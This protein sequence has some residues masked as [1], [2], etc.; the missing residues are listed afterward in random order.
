MKIYRNGKAIELTETEINHLYLEIQRRNYAEE[1]MLKLI[2]DYD[3]DP[4]KE[5]INVMRIVEDV[6]YEIQDNDTIWDCEQEACRKAIERYL[7]ERGIKNEQYCKDLINKWYSDCLKYNIPLSP[8]DV[9][10]I[11]KDLFELKKEKEEWEE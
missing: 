5:N 7:K 6:R 1:V 2:D 10:D 11:V 3:I 8:S 9:E 4:V